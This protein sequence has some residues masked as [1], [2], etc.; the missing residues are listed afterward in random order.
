MVNSE[1]GGGGKE[2]VP[3]AALLEEVEEG[4]ATESPFRRGTGTS[5]LGLT[6]G[7]VPKL[8]IL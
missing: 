2:P 3:A 5:R 4:V 8:S 7:M 1:G 6:V